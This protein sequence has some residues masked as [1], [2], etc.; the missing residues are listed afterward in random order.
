MTL[1]NN[2]APLLCLFKLCESFRRH[3]PIKRGVTAR[4]RQFES[5]STF[6]LAVW[7]CNSTEDIE[8]QYG[9]SSKLLQTLCTISYPL[10]NW[11][12]SYNP[13]TPNLC[14]NPHFFSRVT[15]KFDGWPWKTIGHPFLAS[16]SS[17]HHFIAI[18][19]IQTS[20]YSPETAKWGHNLCDLDL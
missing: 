20:S 3:W 11:N 5:K 10:V 14:Q 16:S 15:L 19:K 9:T 12:W 13:E 18:C 17:A 6:F 7:P 1:K 2:R 8:K 4:K